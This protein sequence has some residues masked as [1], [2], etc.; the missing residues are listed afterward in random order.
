MTVIILQLTQDQINEITEY[1]NIYRRRHHSYDIVYDKNIS[2]VSQNWSNFLSKNNIFKHSNNRNYGENLSSFT[3]YKNDI[4]PL[5]KKS[6][7][8]WY[9]EVK[10]YNFQQPESNSNFQAGHFT[11]LV[12]KSTT[13]FGFGYTYN[14]TKK[15]AKIVMNFTPPGN[16]IGLYSQ[17]VFPI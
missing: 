15:L 17:N 4:I 13:S 16:Y 6:I 1:I 9:S 10:L 7:D 5:L 2:I 8:M 3:G 12:W 11:A 14:T